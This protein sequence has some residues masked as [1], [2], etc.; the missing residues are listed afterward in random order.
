L[1]N[2]LLVAADRQGFPLETLSGPTEATVKLNWR[3]RF[4]QSLT[5]ILRQVEQE[6]TQPAGL[7]RWVQRGVIFVA[8]WLPATAFFA[9]CAVFLWRYFVTQNSQLSDVFLPFVVLLMVLF[10]LHIFVIV[11]L[12]MRWPAIR[13]EFRRRLQV[14]IR[15][16]LEAVY[17]LIPATTAE[18]VGQE[19]RK[20]EKLN[21]DTREVAAWL[22]QHEHSANIAGLYGQ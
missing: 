6:W 21:A 5:E 3:P 13:G 4:A 18:A 10:V 14:R 8:D 20:V 1:I 11:L 16:E 17:D 12:P 9:A 2:R 7:K 22:E 15:L 19:R